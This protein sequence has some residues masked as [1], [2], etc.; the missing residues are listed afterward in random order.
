MPVLRQALNVGSN[1]KMTLRKFAILTIVGF[2]FW[3]C[4]N[5]QATKST[6]DKIT[7]DTSKVE[8]FE[9]AG[10]GDTTLALIYGKIYETEKN[11]KG[12]DTL[13]PLPTVDIRIEQN[14]KAV[15]TDNKGEFK[16]GLK[17]GVFSL[18]ISKQG[19]EPIKLTN[20]VSNPDQVSNAKIILVK[21]TELRKFEIPKWT[22]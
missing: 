1:L 14:N 20:Y 22:R 12:K 15:Q 8:H 5:K 2:S 17:K 7:N 10:Y 19:Y 18:F 13:K 11:I 9:Y 16:I 3:S 21:G 4:S 6:L